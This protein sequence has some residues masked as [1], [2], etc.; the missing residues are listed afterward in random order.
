MENLEEEKYCDI[1]MGNV[2]KKLIF[3]NVQN[4]RCNNT[5]FEFKFCLSKDYN[6]DFDEFKMG[7][8]EGILYGK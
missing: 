2:M 1:W 7:I 4:I 8:I 6:S 3:N 5:G